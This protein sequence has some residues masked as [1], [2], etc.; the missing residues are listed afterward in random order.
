MGTHSRSPQFPESNINRKDFQTS[1]VCGTWHQFTWHEHK[2]VSQVQPWKQ[3][4]VQIGKGDNCRLPYCPKMGLPLIGPII[5][6]TP[7][8]RL[9]TTRKVS[10]VTNLKKK[11]LI[12]L[13][14]EREDLILQ[15]CTIQ[16]VKVEVGAKKVPNIWC[17]FISTGHDKEAPI[18]ELLKLSWPW[19]MIC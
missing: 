9:L 19:R 2:N 8:L 11:H 5:H 18:V 10:W 13:L 17:F 3:A 14:Q 16:T 12:G 7:T 4:G 15:T 1:A 6:P